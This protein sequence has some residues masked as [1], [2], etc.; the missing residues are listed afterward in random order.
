MS[1]LSNAHCS[2]CILADSGVSNPSVHSTDGEAAVREGQRI[3]Y[4]RAPWC[5]PPAPT[6][7]LAILHSDEALVVLNKP[8]GLPVLPSE[9]YYDH[10]V[11]QQLR[12]V[13]GGL[14]GGNA[15]GDVP[16]PVHR[17]GV[18][19]SGVLLC[20]VGAAARGTLSRA[21]E[22]REIS[23][24]YLALV[25]GIVR[26]H[27]KR[28][29]QED[30]EGSN[31]D[32]VAGCGVD[33]D[34]EGGPNEG[35]HSNGGLLAVPSAAT[36]ETIAEA[37]EPAFEV[38]CPIGPVAHSTWAGTVHGAR[39]AAGDGSKEALSVVRVVWRDVRRQ[40]T[41]VEVRI[42]TG[43]PHQIRIHMAY[44]GHPLVG[45]PLFAAGGLPI[46]A[47][48]MPDSRPPL[49]RDTGYLL[50]AWRAELR[51]P[52]SGEWVR[53]IAPPPPELSRAGHVSSHSDKRSQPDTA[54]SC[55]PAD[56]IDQ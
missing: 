38:R 11:L 16:H 43:R 45:D 4:H 20:A 9:V 47:P 1:V 13:H 42:P 40:C 29:A 35:E 5:E 22:S 52:A 10:T 44:L 24:T 15:S 31:A 37:L 3:D 56:A 48:A 19:T 26:K 49:P 41:L 17:L 39:P 27:A 50:H 46:S 18:G 7:D 36:A 53:F 2:A 14:A 33:D 6:S 28:K 30:R 25:S 54:E 32:A 34:N 8:A 12:K 51:H 55:R 21:F 23:K